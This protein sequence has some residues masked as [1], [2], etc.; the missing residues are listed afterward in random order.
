MS[1]RLLWIG[2]SADDLSGFPEQARRRAGYQLRRI[3]EGE[4]PDDW[5]PMPTVG[6]GVR[7]I[8]IEIEDGWF[9][10]FYV[11]WSQDAV[12]VLHSFQKSTTRTAQADIELGQARYKALKAYDKKTKNK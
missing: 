4:E 12:Y 2:S 10:V 11:V 5:R 6:P 7:E 9:R 8:R 1:K 3:Q